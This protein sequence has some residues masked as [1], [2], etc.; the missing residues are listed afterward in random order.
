[1]KAFDA[2]ISGAGRWLQKLRPESLRSK[3]SLAIIVTVALLLELIMAGQ[4]L[5]ARKGIREEVEHRAE[6]E[7]RVKNL[8]VQKVMVSVETAMANI[9]WTAERLLDQPDSLYAVIGRV[10]MQNPTIV[11]AGLMFTE[12]Y[13]PQKGRWFE[14]YVAQRDDG[15]LEC[16]QIGSESHNYLEAEFFKSGMEAAEGNWSE[17]YFDDTGA[18]MM[19]CTY[20]LPVYDSHGQIAALLGADV[21]LDWLSDVIN[22]KQIYPSSFNV[23]V[24]HSGQV[25]VCPVESLVMKTTIQEIALSFN[26]TTASYINRQMMNGR[27]GHDVITGN[28]GE[29]NHVFYAPIDGKTQWSMAVVCNDK[30]IYAGLHRVG[31]YLMLLLIAGM[32][33]LGFI[34]YRAAR[35]AHKLQKAH[36]EK[37]RIGSELRI[38]HGIQQSMLPKTFPPY[39]EREDIDIYALLEPA[40]EVGGDLYDFYIRDGK[41]FF[42]IGDVSGKGV[43]ASLVMAVTRSLFRNVSARE[44]QPETI[45]TAINESM[46]DMNESDM[47]VTLFVGEIDLDTGLMRYCNAGHDAPLL[48]GKVVELLPTDT[49]IPVG[50]MPGWT[51][52]GMEMTLPPMTT[53]FLYTDGLTEAEDCNH[54]QFGKQRMVEMLRE[55]LK[56][57]KTDNRKSASGACEPKTIIAME[58]DAVKRFAGNGE[59]RGGAQEA[60]IQS[61]DLTM[62]A[63][64]YNGGMEGRTLV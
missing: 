1:M 20:T 35:S 18:K 3:S 39:P 12:N 36:D 16:A 51:Y 55:A 25:L 21:S 13:Y 28:D 11:G 41:L 34:I 8:E 19:L 22:A 57:S 26:D 33:L 37:E 38:A 46:A 64:R 2:V 58:R 61:D 15:T 32:A 14:P 10:V 27:G 9:V 42:C 62:L 30:E 53:V 49:N 54:V 56:G 48:I 40:K 63:I 43:P 7:L 4:Y 50:L 45:I 44:D 17:P 59:K 60:D 6:T 52:K 31:F 29:K 5:F 23:L 24:S 47:F